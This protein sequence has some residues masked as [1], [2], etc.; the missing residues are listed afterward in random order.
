MPERQRI[1]PGGRDQQRTIRDAHESIGKADEILAEWPDDLGGWKKSARALLPTIGRLLDEA[2]TPINH[3]GRGISD[4]R[5]NR[6]R[7]TVLHA[8]A[9]PA[10]RRAFDISAEVQTL[11]TSDDFET[12]DLARER[13]RHLRDV[14][15]RQD[16]FT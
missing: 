6:E 9:I 12:N 10:D 7:R 1:T 5:T 16:R 11:A 3:T 14:L 8:L 2:S 13:L 15:N 4:E